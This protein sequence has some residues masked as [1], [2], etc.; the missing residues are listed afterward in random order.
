[1]IGSDWVPDWEDCEGAKEKIG[2]IIFYIVIIG[3]ILVQPFYQVYLRIRR[4][5]Y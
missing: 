4:R 5:K 1:M 3:A 2:L